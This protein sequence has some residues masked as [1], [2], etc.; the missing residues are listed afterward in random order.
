MHFYLDRQLLHLDQRGPKGVL[1]WL[2]EP[3]EGAL[4]VSAEKLRELEGI[5]FRPAPRTV[6]VELKILNFGKFGW[7]SLVAIRRGLPNLSLPADPQQ[8]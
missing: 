5:G 6:I 8:G 1:E 7:V 4:I 2:A 3:A